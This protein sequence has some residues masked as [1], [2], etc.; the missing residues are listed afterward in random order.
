MAAVPCDAQV[1]Q[2]ILKEM[3][4]VEYEPRVVSQLLEF[5]HRYIAIR[6]SFYV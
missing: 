3:G 4:V 1:M 5:A 2:A 6:L